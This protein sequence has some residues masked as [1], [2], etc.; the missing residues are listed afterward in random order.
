MEDEIAGTASK[1]EEGGMLAMATEEE[2]ILPSFCF[3]IAKLAVGLAKV[4]EIMKFIS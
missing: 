2:R 3:S 1:L 4:R